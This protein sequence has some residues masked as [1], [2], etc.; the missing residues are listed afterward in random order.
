MEKPP[1][2]ETIY[3]EGYYLFPENPPFP[4]GFFGPRIRKMKPDMIPE[5]RT[6]PFQKESNSIPHKPEEP[7]GEERIQ[8]FKPFLV[9]DGGS[10][11]PYNEVIRE[12]FF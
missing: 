10:F 1:N 7:F 2:S 4:V 8:F 12:L 6:N 5:F 11:Y 9:I 3:K